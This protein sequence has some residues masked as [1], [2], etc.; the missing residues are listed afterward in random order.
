MT[1]LVCFGG[2]LKFFLRYLHKLMDTESICGG[3]HKK[4]A[5]RVASREGNWENKRSRKGRTL[6]FFSPLNTFFFSF[7]TKCV[8]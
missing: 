7:L 4:L 6:A 8:F 1:P 5:M 3:M 2:F